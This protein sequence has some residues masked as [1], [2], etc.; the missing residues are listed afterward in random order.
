LTDV[1]A[2]VWA[3]V[4]IRHA[5]HGWHHGLIAHLVAVSPRE[6][7]VRRDWRGAFFCWKL[8]GKTAGASVDRKLSN[9]KFRSVPAALEWAEK[10][11]FTRNLVVIREWRDARTFYFE[12]PAGA[13]AAAAGTSNEG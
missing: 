8:Q 3:T 10:S 13:D 11:K 12:G 1:P 6:L 5:N 9:A 4:E 2:H 7:G